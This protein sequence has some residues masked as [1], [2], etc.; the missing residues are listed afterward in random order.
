MDEKSLDRV[1]AIL[2]ES[3]SRVA[4]ENAL[5]QAQQ[6]PV[7][8][9][10]TLIGA[11]KAKGGVTPISVADAKA[12]HGNPDVF[13]VDV[14][15]SK[16]SE[17]NKVDGAVSCPRGLVEF[18]SSPSFPKF[19]KAFTSTES[20]FIVYCGTGGRAWLAGQSL[21]DMGFSKV[22]NMGAMS[23]WIEAKGAISAEELEPSTSNSPTPRKEFKA[24]CLEASPT[25]PKKTVAEAIEL[26]G[27]NHVKFIDGRQPEETQVHSVVHHIRISFSVSVSG[28]YA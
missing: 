19:K 25:G 14:R 13:F 26:H 27:E 15:E 16:E 12:L 10:K 23:G 3:I 4:A 20:T 21:V 6:Q 11:A 24:F 18:I 2:Q 17:G 9:F 22:F 5:L 1:I 8:D 28:R 7:R